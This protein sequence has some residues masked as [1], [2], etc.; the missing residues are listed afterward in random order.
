[1]VIEEICSL[2]VGVVLDGFFC[3]NNV[4]SLLCVGA[5]VVGKV[6]SGG[7]LVD[8]CIS[9]NFAAPFRVMQ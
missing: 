7:P 6:D 2:I 8:G 3:G 4:R 1:M 5:G 9:I